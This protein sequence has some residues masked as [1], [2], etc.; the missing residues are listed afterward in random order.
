MSPV[1]CNSNICDKKERERAESAKKKTGNKNTT[2]Y[3]H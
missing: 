3:L 1:R 2:E